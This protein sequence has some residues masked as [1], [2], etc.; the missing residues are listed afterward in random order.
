LHLESGDGE[1][2]R[3]ALVEEDQTLDFGLWTL[4]LELQS[5]NWCA[6]TNALN[7]LNAQSALEQEDSHRQ[8]ELRSERGNE[9]TSERAIVCRCIEAEGPTEA[10]TRP[11]LESETPAS[12][13]D[14]PTRN[15]RVTRVVNKERKEG[16]SMVLAREA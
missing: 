16:V 2:G 13:S 15:H 4:C 5:P 6:R 12:L 10:S 11:W 7:A 3:D 1:S 9:V 14:E 8:S